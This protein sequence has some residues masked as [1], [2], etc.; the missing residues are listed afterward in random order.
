MSTAQNSVVVEATA[1]SALVEV[2][3]V[4]TDWAFLQAAQIIKVRREVKP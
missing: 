3:N 2:F 1:N 4:Q